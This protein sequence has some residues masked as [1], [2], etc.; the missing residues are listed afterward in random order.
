MIVVP[1]VTRSRKKDVHKSKATIVW[2]GKSSISLRCVRPFTHFMLYSDW[3]QINIYI[4]PSSKS[5]TNQ[6][7][8]ELGTVLLSI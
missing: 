1:A 3:L 5:S 4:F 7:G 2:R 8:L 6:A